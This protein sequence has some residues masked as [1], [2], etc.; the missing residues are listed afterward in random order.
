VSLTVRGDLHHALRAFA[1]ERAFAL[2]VVA[3]LAVC[4]GANAAAFTV[5]RQALLAPLAYPEAD[6]IAYLVNV[7]PGAGI[8]YV[9]AR[10]GASAAVPDYFDRLR[11]TSA[12]SAQ[13]LYTLR[14]STVDSGGRSERVLTMSVTP[15]WF[16]VLRVTPAL[17][18]AFTEQEGSVGTGAEVAVISTGLWRRQ[19]AKR[20]D[21]VG[22]ALNL[23]GRRYTVVGV[24][25]D[26]FEFVEPEV[27]VWIPAAFPPPMRADGA[28]HS[29]GWGHVAR[30]ADGVTPQQ[31]QT[32]IDALNAANRRRFPQFEDLYAAGFQTIVVLLQDEVARD[33]RPAITLVWGGTWCVL[34]IGFV[35][36]ANLVILRVR[37]RF[38]EFATRMALGA[39]SWQIVR[40]VVVENLLLAIG[41]TIGGLALAAAALRVIG[42]TSPAL[43]PHT[44]FAVDGTVI[45]YATVMVTAFTVCLS[46]A[47]WAII[48]TSPIETAVREEGRSNTTGRSGQGFRRVL[49]VAEVGFA[50]VLLVGAGLLVASLAQVLAVDPGFRAGG[51]MTGGLV[52]PAARYADGSVVQR[53]VSDV[54]H[55]LRSVPG[56]VHAGVTTRI[57]LGTL[58]IAQVTVVPEGYRFERGQ[59]PLMPNRVLVTPGYLEA[60]GSSLREGRLFEE[61]DD[62]TSR[63]V[64]IV[65]DQL[66]RH[67]WPD[68]RAVGR[69]LYRP[70]SDGVG[71]DGSSEMVVVGVITTMKLAG[72][73][74]ALD[75]TGTF[76]LP[77]AQ[78]PPA[79]AGRVPFVA[80]RAQGDPRALVAAIRG[81]IA[82]VDRDLPL[83]DVQA[84]DE[85]TA[86]SLGARRFVLA[87][88]L[89][90]GAVGILLS[91]LGIYGVLAY[92]VAQRSR[93]FG[94]RIALGCDRKALLA[95]VLREGALLVIGGLGLGALTAFALAGLVRAQ[96]FGVTAANPWVFA[97]VAALL[98]ASALLACAIPA[99]RATRTDPVVVL[100]T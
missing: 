94:V 71:L 31:A 2:T 14:N 81:A 45:G 37:T 46:A 70:L 41:A 58:G 62:E 51:V 6:R 56:V 7:M 65:D 23:A 57:P 83:F 76:Y 34:V 60:M 52:L 53:R 25:P 89:A 26:G 5:V 44:W 85:R 3:T 13:A 4:L 38:K 50:F 64:V 17:G 11:E 78:V 97:T 69:R 75:G 9:A 54:A 1:R 35:N 16:A 68:G 28:R 24:M 72:L 79:Q 73:D 87:V 39:A 80:V 36:V 15:S 88:A 86:A 10:R 43:L 42:L 100:T 8:G 59:M 74:E 84:M 93:E 90:L 27:S 66:A 47:P 92:W 96:L 63:R 32:Q 99:R 18:R 20:R 95:L 49:I 98:A 12:F 55:R 77:Y 30:F 21:A 19:F 22:Q 82:D 91:C 33:V 40:M 67:F 29:N 48:A 61:G